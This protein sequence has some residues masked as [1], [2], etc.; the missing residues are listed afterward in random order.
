MN[1]SRKCSNLSQ[2]DSVKKNFR[3]AYDRWFPN[4]FIAKNWNLIERHRSYFLVLYSNFFNTELVFLF[5]FRNIYIAFTAI[6]TLFVFFFFRKILI[7]STSILMLFIFLF[8]R[9]ILI[10]LQRLYNI[11]Y[12][13]QEK[14]IKKYLINFFIH[15]TLTY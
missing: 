9:K 1:S 6:L 10:F 3:L 8:S 7:L 5:I 2:Y 11:K 4:A 14:N 15:L 12:L 13:M